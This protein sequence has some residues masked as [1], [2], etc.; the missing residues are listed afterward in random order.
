VRS[1]AVLLCLILFVPIVR[2]QDQENKLMN[3]LLKPDTTLSNTAQNK[4]F[5]ADGAPIDKPANVGTFYIQQKASLKTSSQTRGFRAGQFHSRSFVASRNAANTSSRT[6][7]E[8]VG[9]TVSTPAARGIR[10][11]H[12]AG[13]VADSHNYTGERPFL[14]RGKSQ[15]SLDRHNPEMTIDQVRELLNKNK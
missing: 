3:R 5:V 6:E 15:K 2:G 14:E 8:N 10:Q 1:F 11:T 7:I 13:K 12:D 4:K 9:R